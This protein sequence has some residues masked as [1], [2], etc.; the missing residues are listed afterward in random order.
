M[1]ANVL[2]DEERFGTCS[3]RRK[4]MGSRSGCRY[5]R[6]VNIERTK[7]VVGISLVLVATGCG[8]ALTYPSRVLA[9]SMS[10]PESNEEDPCPRGC[11]NADAST[12]VLTPGYGACYNPGFQCSEPLVG[13]VDAGACTAQHWTYVPRCPATSLVGCC[14]QGGDAG[15]ANCW[16][17]PYAAGAMGQRMQSICQTTLGTW[18]TTPP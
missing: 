6:A 13:V 1:R 8:I 10:A 12:A 11:E 15:I 17:A 9:F 4:G 14:I 2:H 5:P 16:Y 18:R 3:G 7:R